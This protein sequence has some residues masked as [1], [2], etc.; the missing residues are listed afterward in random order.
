MYLPQVQVNY[1]RSRVI[2]SVLICILGTFWNVSRPCSMCL[3]PPPFPT[4]L[5]VN[6][7]LCL[8]CLQ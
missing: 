8:L 6:F 7:P 1:E 2:S 3:A 4:P 5:S